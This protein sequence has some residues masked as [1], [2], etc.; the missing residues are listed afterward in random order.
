[1]AIEI[2]EVVVEEG[3]AR[4]VDRTMAPPYSEEISW[5]EVSVKGLSNAPGKRAQLAVQGVIGGGAALDLRGE[6]APLGETLFVDLDGEL[7]DF[8]IPRANPFMDR[9]L[10]WIAREGSITTR[11]HYRIEGDRLVATNEIVIGRLELAQAGERDEV[12]RRLGLPLGL[13]VALMKDARGEI[14]VSLPVSGRLGAPEFSFGEAIWTAVKNVVMNILSAPFKLIGKL[15]TK[16]GTIEA[17]TIDPVRFEPGSAA[18]SPATE[19]HLQRVGE[20]LKASPFVRL[21]LAPVVTGA[22][23]ASLKT[24]EVTARI[25]RVQREQ[26]IAEFSAA[27]ARVFARQLPDRPVPKAAEVMVSMLRDAEPEPDAEARALAARRVQTTRETLMRAAGIAAERLP[28]RE[29]PVPPGASGD[30]RVEFSIT[31]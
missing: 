3:Y 13:I 27:A 26:R 5:I 25:Q 16:G 18:L 17:V 21:T 15:F 30:G 31:Q 6:V 28:E 10:A 12:K 7:R 11:V 22:D 2:G 19:Q 20:F 14:R 9:I 8:T 4:F 29:A 24:Q 1:M 23:V